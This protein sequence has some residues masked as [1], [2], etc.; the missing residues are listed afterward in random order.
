MEM[1]IGTNIKRLRTIKNITQEQL[2]IAMNVTCAAVSKWE[3]GDTYPDITLLQPLAYYFGVTLDELMGYDQKKIQAKI[4]DVIALYRQYWNSDFSKAREIIINAYRDYPNDYWIMHY[5]MW[6]LAGDMS[7]N[8]PEVLLKHKDEF[9][10]IC[11]KILEGCTEETLRLN[12]W[13]MRAKL[14]H[15]EGKTEEALNIYREKYTNWYHTCGQKTEQLFSKDTD[16]Y[17]YWV[18]KNMYELI[19][20]AGYKLASVIF[21]DKSLTTNDKSQKAI[22]Y[23]NLILKMLDETDDIFFAGLAEAFLGRTRSY[24]MYRGGDDE[25]IITVLDMNLR[26]SKKIAD[27]I[28]TDSAIRQAYFPE[29]LSVT[30]NDYLAWIVESLLTP[31][32]KRHS[33]LLKNPAYADVLSKYR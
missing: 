10:V 32:D 14:L 26:A 23:G 21:F 18:S 27:A 11:D 13:N 31:R 30:A 12:A 7:D 17:Y 25:D 15:A 8:N 6:N 28:N 9:L 20:F 19:A 16:E 4:D 1:T 22:K 33:E 29:Q 24:L 2:S 5:Y 3:R